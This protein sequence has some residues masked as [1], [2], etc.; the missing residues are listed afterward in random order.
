MFKKTIMAGV[1]AVTFT[2]GLAPAQATSGHTLTGNVGIFSQY[3]FRGLTQ[4]NTDPALQGG[5]DYSHAS[6]LYA[7]TWLS[8]ISWLT[9]SPVATGYT[10]SSLEWDFYGGYKGTFGKSDFGYDIGLLQYYYPGSRNTALYPGTVKADTLEAY[11]ALTWKWLSLKYSHSLNNKTFGVANS[12]GTYYLDLTANF[13]VSD[14]LT[15]IAHY[16]KQKFEGSNGGVSND[17]VASYEDYK[18]GLSYALPKDFTVGGFFSGTSMD[19]T[20]KAF[21][22]NTASNRFVGKDTFTVFVQKTF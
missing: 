9:D 17:A 1:V 15:L 18:L 11:A 7:G 21:Y 22:T 8:N 19:S 10:S 3:I 4:T 16:G 13:P 12:S 5:F 6:G 20:Q 2:P 14:K